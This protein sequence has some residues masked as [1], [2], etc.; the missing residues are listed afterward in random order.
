MISPDLPTGNIQVQIIYGFRFSGRR[1]RRPLRRKANI[2]VNN[3]WLSFFGTP[4]ASSPTPQG[5]FHFAKQN[6]TDF[7]L[8]R[9]LRRH[10]PHGACPFCRFATFSP[11]HRGNLPQRGKQDYLVL[12]CFF[13]FIKIYKKNN[14][15]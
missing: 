7:N 15:I 11:F 5:K 4:R 8:Y 13:V 1:G 3:L 14:K 2:T 6:I 10:S 9:R 12:L